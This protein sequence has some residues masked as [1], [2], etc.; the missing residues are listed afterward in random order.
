MWPVFESMYK[1]FKS[2][3]IDYLDG[4]YGGICDVHY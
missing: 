1:L 3:A 2:I 4:K